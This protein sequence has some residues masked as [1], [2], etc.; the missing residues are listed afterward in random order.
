MKAVSRKQLRKFPPAGL[1]DEQ[2]AVWRQCIAKR[3]LRTEVAAALSAYA[4]GQRYYQCPKCGL[5]HL[6]TQE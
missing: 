2:L 5:Y 4:R 1:A 6:T 3:A